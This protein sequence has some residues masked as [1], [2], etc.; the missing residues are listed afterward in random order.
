[1]PEEQAAATKV[2]RCVLTSGA[3]CYALAYQEEVA[4]LTL[5]V[6]EVE[7][8]N[9]E[10]RRKFTV[11]EA[12]DAMLAKENA[13]LR[14]VVEAARRVAKDPYPGH[15][16]MGVG[17]QALVDLRALLAALTPEKETR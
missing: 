16:F 6:R 17:Y 15:P 7:E 2:G 9:A 5:R 8:E 14:A 12:S 13:R 3:I 11:Y 1:M 10:C 4:A